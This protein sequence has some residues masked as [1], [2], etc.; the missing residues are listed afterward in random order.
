MDDYVFC[1]N[2]HLLWEAC[3]CF[4][5]KRVLVC[6]GRGYLDYKRLTY[7]LDKFQEKV[8]PIEV[9]IHGDA[10]GADTLAGWYAREKDIRVEAYPADWNRYGKQAGHLRNRQMLDEGKPD[11][12]IAFPGGPG[13]KNMVYNAE[14]SGFK[15]YKI[16]W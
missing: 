15:V 10:R 4:Y 16:D 8:A 5:K 7:A 1:Q 9:I 11:V 14:A 3:R 13:T 2:C 6:G 12:I